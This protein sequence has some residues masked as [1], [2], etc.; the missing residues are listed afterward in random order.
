MTE[1]MVRVIM[2]KTIIVQSHDS[3][4]PDSFD[5]QRKSRVPGNEKP[6]EL[7]IFLTL[8]VISLTLAFMLFLD[9]NAGI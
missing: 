4:V 9:L 7:R 3:L 2:E 1:R 5:R 6:S 8:A